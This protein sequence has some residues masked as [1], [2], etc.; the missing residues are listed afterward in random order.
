MRFWGSMLGIFTL[1]MLGGL[2]IAG[3]WALTNYQLQ[4]DATVVEGQ[5]IDF[6]GHKRKV[7]MVRYQR[8]D[9]SDA[10]YI[11][12]LSQNPPAYYVGETV[13]VLIGDNGRVLLNSWSELWLGPLII[14]G[15]F[16]FLGLMLSPFLVMTFNSWRDQRYLQRHGQRVYA[17]IM[18]I[19]ENK[20]RQR[21]DWQ[22]HCHW[23]D[24]RGDSMPLLFSSP[25]LTT[26]PR[27][28]VG[29]DMPILVCPHNRQRYLMDISAIPG[30]HQG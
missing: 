26:D 23:Q 15:M 16:S 4:Q 24:P 21:S 30:Y 5:V 11:S 14:G 3:Y 28:F 10:T 2:G 13:P 19:A 9:G 6:V 8:P 7:P 25:T 17:R 12:K 18:T 1:V 20:Q 27:P 29:D 22:I